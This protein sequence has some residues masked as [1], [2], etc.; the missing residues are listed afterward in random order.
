[1]SFSA[2]P[3]D[4]TFY[5]K[6]Y[7]SYTIKKKLDPTYTAS[8]AKYY[9]NAYAEC[10]SM[11]ENHSRQSYR[12]YLKLINKILSSSTGSLLWCFPEQTKTEREK[13]MLFFHLPLLK[14]LQ[15]LI[16]MYYLEAVSRD[17]L[18]KSIT[19]IT[20]RIDQGIINDNLFQLLIPGRNDGL[21]PS[22]AYISRPRSMG[23]IYLTIPLADY[24][25]LIKNYPDRKE[26]LIAYI[27]GL[28]P[29]QPTMRGEIGITYI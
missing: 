20:S 21:D 17:D 16:A 13:L 14:D 24:I 10:M 2:D 15:C 11:K 5:M 1:M 27:N 22:I 25:N 6:T 4:D 12:S 7:L 26:S 8:G 9:M 28:H 29:T 23:P 3:N 19:R 18:L